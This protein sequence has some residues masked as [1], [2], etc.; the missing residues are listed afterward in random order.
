MDPYPLSIRGQKYL[1]LRNY[2]VQD[3]GQH[4]LPVEG[5]PLSGAVGSSG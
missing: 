1:R 3:D 2:L 5:I 4:P